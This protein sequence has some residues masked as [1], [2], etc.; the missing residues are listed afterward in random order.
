MVDD[1]ANKSGGKDGRI[2]SRRRIL[3]SAGGFIAATAF[4]GEQ[5][6][7][8]AVPRRQESQKTAPLAGPDITGRL[9]RYMVA[10]RSTNLPPM[11]ALEGKHPPRAR[12]S[13][14]GHGLF[15]SAEEVHQLQ[16][17]ALGEE[18]DTPFRTL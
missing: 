14:Y 18:H 7:I 11:V 1:R 15:G 13:L 2:L 8:A 6:A 4:P 9:A 5:A 3:Q 17:K 16:L 10:A 12:P